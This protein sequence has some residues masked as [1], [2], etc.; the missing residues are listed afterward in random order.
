MLTAIQ[1]YVREKILLV[2]AYTLEGLIVSVSIMIR[3]STFD[4]K[5]ND[6]EHISEKIHIFNVL[7]CFVKM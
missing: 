7:R 6:E 4:E 3:S 5:V 2:G 1:L